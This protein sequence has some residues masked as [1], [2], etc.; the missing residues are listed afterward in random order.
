M[1]LSK[2]IPQAFLMRELFAS[3]VRYS[4][5]AASLIGEALYWCIRCLPTICEC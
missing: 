5:R 3:E 2:A 4:S 1:T